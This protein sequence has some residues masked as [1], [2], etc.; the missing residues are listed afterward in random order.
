MYASNNIVDLAVGTTAAA[1]GEIIYSDWA[2]GRF[3]VPTG[4]SITTITWYDAIVPGGDY[5]PSND[6]TPEALTQTVAAGQSYEIPPSL[7]GA[8]SL[9][10]VGDAAGTVDVALKG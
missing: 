10:L 3:H 4:S 6:A 5:L 2:G 1:S 7:A 8:A 9:K